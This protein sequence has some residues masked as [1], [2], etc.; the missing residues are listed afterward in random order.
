MRNIIITFVLLSIAILSLRFSVKN[1]IRLWGALIVA[2]IL[3]SLVTKT[4]NF[5]GIVFYAMIYCFFAYQNPNNI[6]NTFLTY[7]ARWILVIVL[8]LRLLQEIIIYYLQHAR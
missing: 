8:S 1:K 3:L 5:L 4:Y 2:I 6:K 7:I